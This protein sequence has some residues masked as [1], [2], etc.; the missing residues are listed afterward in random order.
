MS[1]QSG[2]AQKTAG[3]ADKREVIISSALDLF[4]H[5]GYRRTSME[6][7]A[8]A[9]AVAKGTLYLYFKSK[10]ELFEAICRTLAEQVAEGV[11]AAEALDLPLE[12]KLAALME[13]KLGFVYRWILSSPHAAE[14]VDSGSRLKENVFGDVHVQFQNA[15]LQLVR[16]GT[17]RGELDPKASGLTQ[18]AAA[19]T[20][21]AAACG[22]EKAPDEETFRRQLAAIIKLTL[23]GL[24]A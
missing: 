19:E 7:I 23:R 12:R 5:Y 13:A 9:A 16:E 3:L 20:L 22:A 8:R 14:L 15:V 2:A 6:D 1:G 11:T 21:I 24:R 10:D 4:R 17:Q 18:E